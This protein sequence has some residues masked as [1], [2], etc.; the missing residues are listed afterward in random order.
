MN[1]SNSTSWLKGERRMIASNSQK[2]AEGWSKD[3]CEQLH[4][5][6]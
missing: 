2:L 3:E 4:K 5:L 6:A 1:A